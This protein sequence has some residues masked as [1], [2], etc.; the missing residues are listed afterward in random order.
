[1]FHF[2]AGE[3]RTFDLRAGLARVRCPVLVLGGELDPVC[4]IED[5]EEIAA[6]LPP[7]LVRFERFA[8][9]GHGVF[10]DDPQ[11]FFAVLREFLAA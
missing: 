7:A 8:D 3:D 4:P 5:Q 1:M 10:R 2:A 6:A 11:R 9:C